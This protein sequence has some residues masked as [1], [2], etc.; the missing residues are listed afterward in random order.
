MNKHSPSTRKDS[1]PSPSDKIF[2]QYIKSIAR[3]Q[4]AIDSNP[5]IEK[6]KGQTMIQI[7]YS[8][9]GTGRKCKASYISDD[10]PKTICSFL[11]SF[12]TSI[13]DVLVLK[14]WKEDVRS[15][16]Y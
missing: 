5:P 13:V 7:E 10:I 4:K 1:I 6:T 3:S 16:K 8:I 12:N 15:Q 14:A 11:N 2:S 9:S